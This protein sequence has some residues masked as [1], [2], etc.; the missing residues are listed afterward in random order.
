[1]KKPKVL[2]ADEPTGALDE[3]TRD[4]ILALLDGLWKEYG[5]TFIMVTHDSHIAKR[6]PRIATIKKGQITVSD[7]TAAK[8]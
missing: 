4:D 7:R 3:G 5:L 8:Q 6:A 2:L 1:V